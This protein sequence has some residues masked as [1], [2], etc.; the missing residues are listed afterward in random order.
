MIPNLTFQANTDFDVDSRNFG[1]I[2][3]MI[4]Q[5]FNLG[6]NLGGMMFAILCVLMVLAA[7]VIYVILSY[8]GTVLRCH[9]QTLHNLAARDRT[10]RSI[11]EAVE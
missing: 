4:S 10:S 2:N 6:I 11:R 5:N 1:L 8:H 3:S 7:I 9:R